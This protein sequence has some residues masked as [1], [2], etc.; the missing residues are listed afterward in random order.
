MPPNNIHTSNRGEQEF[1]T[2]LVSPCGNEAETVKHRRARPQSTMSKELATPA[3]PAIDK[4][5]LR[6]QLLRMIVKREQ[7]RRQIAKS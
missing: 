7:E 3:A 6:E 4:D 1:R 5:Q 2:R